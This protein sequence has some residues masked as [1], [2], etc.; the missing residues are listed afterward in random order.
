MSTDAMP[1]GE[2]NSVDGAVGETKSAEGL[3]V[4]E[5]K[6]ADGMFK[7]FGGDM[8]EPRILLWESAMKHM[9]RIKI[10]AIEVNCNSFSKHLLNIW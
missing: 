10:Y 1:V 8:W 4:G 6:L 9:L 5:I 2:L 7:S 3:S